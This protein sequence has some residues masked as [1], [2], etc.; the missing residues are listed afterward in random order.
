MIL[1]LDLDSIIQKALG[2]I[3]NPPL[4]TFFL[5][6]LKTTALE[7]IVPL[8]HLLASSTFKEENIKLSINEGVP[9]RSFNFLKFSASQ[10]RVKSYVQS[11]RGNA[12]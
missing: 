2:E 12:I 10:T 11:C 6:C 7:I 3:L 9:F 1:V 4:L 5:P 8:H